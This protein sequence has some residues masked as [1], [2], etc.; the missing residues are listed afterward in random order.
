MDPFNDMLY[1]INTLNSTKEIA[2]ELDM[3]LSAEN[4]TP[5]QVK[6]VSK[7][8]CQNVIV[9]F[10]SKKLCYNMVI[11]IGEKY[12][13]YGQS[14]TGK[15]TLF[16]VLAGHTAYSGTIFVDDSANVTT[17][18]L[19][20]DMCYSYRYRTGDS[21]PPNRLLSGCAAGSGFPFL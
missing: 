11:T 9:D 12:V 13:L 10:G 6:P 18:I 16:K 17:P 8:S 14:G 20:P 7:I 1:C 15:S 3:F 21:S 2:H 5:I 19:T 4:H